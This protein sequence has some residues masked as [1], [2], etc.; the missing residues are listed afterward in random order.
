M[1]MKNYILV[2]ITLLIGGQMMAQDYSFVVAKTGKTITLGT[3][4][5]KLK[6]YDVVFFGE[7]HDNAD[8][9]AAQLA[10]LEQMYISNKRLILSF[11]MFERDVQPLLDSYLKGEI[12]EADFLA[13][14]RAWSN[15]ETDYKPLLE[16]ARANG[17]QC[18][19]ANVPRRL[20]GKAARSG[21]TF[22][23]TL[24]EEELSYIAEELNIPAGKYRNNFF[25]TMAGNGMHG[26]ADDVAFMD[27]LY[28]AQCLK[29]DTM[30]EAIL[31]YRKQKPKHDVLHFNGDFHSR[32]FLGTVERCLWRVPK[33]KVAV[34]APHFK[35]NPLPDNAADIATYF[36][37][38]P[39]PPAE[40]TPQEGTP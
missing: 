22:C 6:A 20:A 29:D 11:E 3:L 23:E 25:Q 9:H 21:E 33:L 30:A 32:E 38:I 24:S 13:G 7:Y 26:S 16:F 36:V 17:L 34:I 8:I 4:A 27:N 14:A 18:I 37:V 31:K 2:L 5:N 39:E 10:L 12:S 28:L 1:N 19:A 35:S 15:Y 40:E